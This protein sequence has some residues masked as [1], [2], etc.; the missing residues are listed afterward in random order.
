VSK[1]ADPAALDW[2]G[3]IR[4]GI[5][6][7]VGWGFADAK[8][9]ERQIRHLEEGDVDEWIA[10]AD[11]FTEKLGGQDNGAFGRWLENKVGKLEPRRRDL[12]DA[13]NSLGCPI[14]T[15]NYDDILTKATI[16]KWTMSQE[17]QIH[18]MRSATLTA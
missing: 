10:V 5:E 8:W 12:L 3:L 15:T 1:A 6:E 14:A 16:V 4:S 11:L 9:Q 2:R 13:I 17:R 7:S 18:G